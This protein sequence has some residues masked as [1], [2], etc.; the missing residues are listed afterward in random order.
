[1]YSTLQHEQEEV[2]NFGGIKTKVQTYLSVEVSWGQQPVVCFFCP[3]QTT[4][5][6]DWLRQVS[7]VVSL[8]N[9]CGMLNNDDHLT[10]NFPYDT[11]MC[12]QSHTLYSLKLTIHRVRVCSFI[13]LN[14]FPVPWRH[15]ATCRAC[16]TSRSYGWQSQP[17]ERFRC[18]CWASGRTG[19]G[20]SVT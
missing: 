5:I 1:M 2:A 19:S 12:I 7:I 18:R 6:S 17:V 14:L 13:A 20:D 9:F 8:W 4:K 16:V 11:C 15:D 3:E 10:T